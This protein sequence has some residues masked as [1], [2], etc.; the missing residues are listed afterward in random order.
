[1][2]SWL[3]K[4]AVSILTLLPVI[5]INIG[6]AN[7]SLHNTELQIKETTPL[8][9]EHATTILEQAQD[10]TN[11]LA[12]HYSHSSHQSHSSHYSHESHHSHY[13]SRY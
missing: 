8:Y 3:K 9:L 4:V 12:W 13:S 1:M 7:A 10:K 11:I 2:K 5:G 6:S